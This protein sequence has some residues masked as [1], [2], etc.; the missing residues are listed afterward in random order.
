MT[1][2]LKQ[3]GMR[4]E[5]NGCGGSRR[6]AWW[7][8]HRRRLCN[9]ALLKGSLSL[10]KVGAKSPELSIKFF[11]QHRGRWSRHQHQ[12]VVCVRKC[13]RRQ[14]EAKTEALRAAQHAALLRTAG[15]ARTVS[16]LV[17]HDSLAM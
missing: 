6:A 11:Q 12:Q 10:A 16:P 9:R 4:H 13:R 1:T 2:L 17:G 14:G 5:K 8:P 3:A 15:R 7:C